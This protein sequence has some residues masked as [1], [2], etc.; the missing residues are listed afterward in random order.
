[1]EPIG[2]LEWQEEYELGIEE[3]DREHK[4]I[5]NVL[6]EIYVTINE[7][8]QVEDKMPKLLEAFDFYATKHTQMEESYAEK[9]DFPK[10]EELKESHN[11]F[12][13][14]YNQLRQYYYERSDISQPEIQK[15]LH[16]HS[17]MSK[18]LRVH[19]RTLDKELCDFLKEKIKE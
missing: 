18:W 17:L 11:F 1:M 9:Y 3:I 8:K 15:I 16:L 2:I 6:N 12:K 14:T 10:T 7:G 5:I 13:T 19:L 4:E